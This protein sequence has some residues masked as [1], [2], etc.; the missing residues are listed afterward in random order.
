MEID[1][2]AEITAS[3]LTALASWAESACKAMDKH[4]G[5]CDAKVSEEEEQ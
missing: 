5:E 4:N 2:H 1:G 3:E